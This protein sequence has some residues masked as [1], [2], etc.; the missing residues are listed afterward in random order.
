[1]E[2]S[3]ETPELRMLNRLNKWELRENTLVHNRTY[4]ACKRKCLNI[5]LD[6]RSRK[7]YQI[8]EKEG[9]T[10]RQNG[11]L[12]REPAAQVQIK[13]ESYARNNEK[14]SSAMQQINPI[15]SC[16]YQKP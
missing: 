15:Y 6:L 12:K 13:A 4:Y 16:Q 2:R 1:M 8:T 7:K 10:E 5:H 14:D 3:P 9:A 11:Y